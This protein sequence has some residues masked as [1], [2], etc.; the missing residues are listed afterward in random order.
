MNIKFKDIDW[1]RIGNNPRA[2]DMAFA[3]AGIFG[4]IIIMG[5]MMTAFISWKLP[6]DPA[7][8]RALILCIL[9]SAIFY[10]TAPE[11]D[12]RDE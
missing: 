10:M 1:D 6:S 12:K 7:V 2:I 5:V 4:G 9:P 11:K 8:L 3:I